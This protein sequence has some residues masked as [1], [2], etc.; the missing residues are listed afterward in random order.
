MPAHRVYPTRFSGNAD[1]YKERGG[2]ASIIQGLAVDNAR[3]LIQVA[4]IPDFTDNSTGVVSA[5]GIVDIRSPRV[6]TLNTANTVASLSDLNAA[7]TKVYNAEAVLI[8]VA[9]KARTVLGLPLGVAAGGV[10]AT[11]GTIPALTKSVASSTS[12]SAV[13]FASAKGA[14]RIA[15]QNL[16]NVVR[17]INEV[18]YAVGLPEVP[19]GSVGKWTPSLALTNVQAAASVVG[20][21]SALKTEVDAALTAMANNIATLAARW[22]AAMTQGVGGVGPLRVVATARR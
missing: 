17:Q 9:N 18:I 19:E 4:G 1:V 12:T 16:R 3:I 2:L 20:G 13:D 21:N 22:N 7:L 5:A 10:V 6:P 14:I 8:E 15:E 11:S